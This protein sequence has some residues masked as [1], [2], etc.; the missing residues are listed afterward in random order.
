MFHVPLAD[1]ATE[2]T[3][4]IGEIGT[5]DGRGVQ[6]GTGNGRVGK[7]FGF[8]VFVIGSRKSSI[9]GRHDVLG[10]IRIGHIVLLE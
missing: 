3:G 1:V 8:F 6:D 10:R 4:N 5:G 9:S 2:N 7:V